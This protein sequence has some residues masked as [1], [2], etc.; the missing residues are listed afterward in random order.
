MRLVDLRI[1]RSAHFP[2]EFSCK[3]ARM[4]IMHN[5]PTKPM[6][7]YTPAPTSAFLCTGRRRERPIFCHC[8]SVAS[9]RSFSL[10]QPYSTDHKRTVN[11]WYRRNNERIMLEEGCIV[12]M[13]KFMF[14]VDWMEKSRA[15]SKQTSLIKDLIAREYRGNSASS[16]V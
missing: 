14:H 3:I 15:G 5:Y 11:R 16:I 12:F 7:M 2:A 13:I 10:D 4:L 8:N 9:R 1:K 6:Q